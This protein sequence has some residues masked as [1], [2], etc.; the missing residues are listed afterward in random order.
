[1][2]TLVDDWKRDRKSVEKKKL[3][4]IIPN[5]NDGNYL[6]ENT[7]IE[8][9]TYLRNIDSELLKK[10]IDECLNEKVTVQKKDIQGYILQ[11]IVNE[12]GRR[13]G[14]S[15]EFG[16]LK[17]VRNDNGFDGLWVDSDNFSI[18]VEVKTTDTYRI[19][20][21]TVNKYRKGLIEEGKIS[22][23]SKSS[24]LFVVGRD[25]TGGLEAQIRGSR[26]AW[27]TRLISID[28]LFNLLLIKEGVNDAATVDQIH[29]VIKPQEYT[30]VDKLIDL[31]F[32]TTQDSELGDEDEADS[33]EPVV[34]KNGN[35]AQEKRAKA[36]YTIETVEKISNSLKIDLAKDIKKIYTDSDKKTAIVTMSSS[37]KTDI[38][39]CD[40][41]F[42]IWD[43]YID[44]IKNYEKSYFALAC[45]G[46]D[47][48]LYVPCEIIRKYIGKMTQSVRKS[49]KRGE[50]VGKHFKFKIVDDRIQLVVPKGKNVDFTE[51]LIK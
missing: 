24:M 40:Y 31:I 11:D 30:R 3:F 47:M 8:F 15:V 27:D 49:K 20:V 36:D 22:D 13:L 37:K 7:Y 16:R 1:M 42:T 48:L 33:D 6:T 44:N 39:G 45:G 14:F 29:E 43:F 9:R 2:S 5:I 12:I 38:P 28:S 51:Y 35:E 32:S 23:D 19:N 34:D 4:Q 10:Y 41:W 18:V 17:G 25:E 50:S 26:Y 21:E 46:T